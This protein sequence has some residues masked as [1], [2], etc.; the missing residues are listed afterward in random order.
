MEYKGKL[1]ELTKWKPGVICPVQTD[2]KAKSYSWR[3]NV[4]EGK[5]KLIVVVLRGLILNKGRNPLKGMTRLLGQCQYTV[6]G[7]PQ[8]IFNSNKHHVKKNNLPLSP[9]AQ[10]TLYWLSTWQRCV[11]HNGLNVQRKAAVL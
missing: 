11:L 2:L 8:D 7:E 6:P 9:S 1:W 4:E 10:I 3:I 5:L